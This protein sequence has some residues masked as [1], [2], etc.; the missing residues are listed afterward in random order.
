MMAIFKALGLFVLAGLFEIGGGYLMWQWLRSGKPLWWGIV[1]AVML[2]FYGIV[3]TWQVTS[4]GKT[5]AVYGAI[6]IV[7]SIAWAGYF[8]GFKPDRLD[9]IGGLIVMVGVSV[10][11]F[12]PRS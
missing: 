3:A 1:G 6:F 2:V 9:L 7:M 5:Y 10:I 4:F 11:L 12:W 8:D